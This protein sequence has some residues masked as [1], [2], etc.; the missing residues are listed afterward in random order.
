MLEGTRTLISTGRSSNNVFRFAT[1]R[2]GTGQQ[3][4]EEPLENNV[5]C[6][7][8]PS[9]IVVLLI[10]FPMAEAMRENSVLGVPLAWPWSR[11]CFASAVFA[12]KADLFRIES[13]QV[14]NSFVLSWIAMSSRRV[15]MEEVLNIW[16]VYEWRRA[17]Q[18]PLCAGTDTGH[19]RPPAPHVR[20]TMSCAMSALGK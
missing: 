13:T 6:A 8:F 18:P 11:R 4:T 1:R 2:I 16:R 5:R 3:L 12:G 9:L 7:S 10:S 15:S 14:R 19:C 17:Q 20:P